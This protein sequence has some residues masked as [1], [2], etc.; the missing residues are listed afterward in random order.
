[1]REHGADVRLVKM[2][3]AGKNMTSVSA[4]SHGLGGCVSCSLTSSNK[5]VV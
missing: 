1:M 3:D 4:S 2:N 5:A